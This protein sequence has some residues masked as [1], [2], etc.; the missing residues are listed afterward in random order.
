LA[1]RLRK[2]IATRHFIESE[3]LF[4]TGSV[5]VMKFGGTSVGDADPLCR[6]AA[7]IDAA[8]REHPT[9]AVVSAMSGVTNALV[10]AA[11]CAADGDLGAGTRLSDWLQCKHSRVAHTL[12]ADE[13]RRRELQSEIKLLASAAGNWCD[14][15]A[16]GRRFCP[17]LA[18]AI[19]S[20]GERLAARLLAAALGE[21]GI[22]S[23]AVDA[24]SVIVTNEA[25]GAAEPDV[26]LT[27]A[28]SRLQ[29]L[30]LLSA[31]IVPVVTGF[32]GAT[33]EGAVT[34]L[35]RGGS[36]YSATLLG[37]AL[38]ASEVII[39]TDVDGVMTA[40]PR[41]APE[42]RTIPHLSY[43][44][45][46]AIAE[47]GAKVLHPKTLRPVA[48]RGIPVRVQNSFAPARLGTLITACA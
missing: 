2:P 36:D 47:A 39:W 18:D 46:A 4:M 41:I 3:D 19:Y 22:L 40:D 35:G 48:A 11:R 38:D 12:V 37:A 7:I 45:A 44:A 24:S 30:P 20:I 31:G 27:R 16:E 43:A 10:E 6:A 1:S 32:I 8:Q 15:L 42:A 14:R 33:A 9:L 23:V 34:T 13:N 28:R 26:A 5:R 21:R 25:H 17:Q 29:L